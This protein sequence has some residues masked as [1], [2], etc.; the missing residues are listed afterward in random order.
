MLEEFLSNIRATC[1]SPLPVR[2]YRLFYCFYYLEMSNLAQYTAFSGQLFSTSSR[3]QN[4]FNGIDS[5][6]ISFTD[7][8]LLKRIRRIIRV[9]HYTLRREN[10]YWNLAKRYILFNLSPDTHETRKDCLDGRIGVGVWSLMLFSKMPKQ[11]S[12]CRVGY[13]RV[14][15][16]GSDSKNLITAIGRKNLAVPGFERR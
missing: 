5:T 16:K 11:N 9:K 6:L 1:F 4:N 10:A 7:E 14:G 2:K 13:E 12:R 8:K 3:C 15:Y